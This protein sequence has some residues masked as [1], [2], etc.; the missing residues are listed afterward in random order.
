MQTA[1]GQ[2]AALPTGLDGVGRDGHL[3]VCG[4]VLLTGGG[5]KRLHSPLEANGRLVPDGR[6]PATLLRGI[7][8]GGAGPPGPVLTWWEGTDRSIAA[9][10]CSGR[11][12]QQALP[13]A[14]PR[15][16][17]IDRYP[18]APVAL[19]TEVV[20]EPRVVCWIEAWWSRSQMDSLSAV[21]TGREME[22]G[23][24]RRRP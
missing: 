16:A 1:H 13:G 4:G 22:A 3:A 7:F 5:R 15:D 6:E 10:V 21:V 2:P 20:S 19:D 24:I 18:F 8:P 9:V 17:P 14:P 11:Q 23:W 12:V